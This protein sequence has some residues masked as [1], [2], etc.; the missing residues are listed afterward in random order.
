MLVFTI[1]IAECCFLEETLPTMVHN[2]QT[3]EE[4][5]VDCEKAAFLG[6]SF[7]NDSQDSLAISIVDAL[8][9][10]AAVPAPSHISIS[11]LLTAPTVLILLASFSALSLH[12]STFDVLLPHLG[13][14]AT[15]DIGLGLPCTWLHPVMLVIKVIAASSM[16]FL[17]SLVN[18]VGLVHLYR[19]IS[20]VFPAL[21]VVLPVVALA[22]TTCGDSAI[23]AGIFSTLATLAKTTLTRAAQ[24]LVLLLVLSTAPDASST[25]TL[26]GVISISEMF[27][28]LAVGI[29][30]VSYFLS[31]D[32]SVLV[33]NGAL[34]TVLAV[35]ASIGGFVTLRLRETS[36]VGADL[37]EEC[38]VWQGM[39][40]IDSEDE[41]GF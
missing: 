29:A 14:H 22:A 17:P 16:L 10:D 9:D 30:G 34:W 36:R 31:D 39:F 15:H 13:Q 28:A 19:R 35:I 23:I 33:V 41:A 40:D 5:Y 38:L 8:K 1:A 32:Y 3:Q 18:R 37:P 25:G 20:V 7:A 4:E 21:Y 11:Q 2:T 26:I 24:V 6:Q 12:S 27:K